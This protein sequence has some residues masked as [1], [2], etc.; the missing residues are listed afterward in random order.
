MA[1]E[2]EQKIII[3]REYIVPLRREYL[4]VPKYRRAKRAVHALKEFIAQHMKIY[5]RDLRKVKVD[6][7]LNN[8]IRFRGMRSPLPKVRVKA[9]KYEDGTVS[10][11]L[12]DIPKHIEFEMARNVRKQVES[13]KKSKDSEET[14]GKL[15]PEETA[16]VLGKEKTE[17]A[18]A[19]QDTKEKEESS[20]LATEA[21]EKQK[22]KQM[23]HTSKM[24]NETPKIQ[25]KALKR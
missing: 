19:K 2:K 3:E 15:K 25:R 14:K 9:I 21:F 10:V 8:E 16:G 11:K 17:D 12:V 1:D 6:V 5:D 4:N 7:Y 22:A 13:L 18:A 20:K 23:E 24:A